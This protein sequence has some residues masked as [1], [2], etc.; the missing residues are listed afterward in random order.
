MVHDD[1]RLLAPF[2]ILNVHITDTRLLALQGVADA[3][4]RP[5]CAQPGDRAALLATPRAYGERAR[6]ACAFPVR[7]RPPNLHVECG[8]P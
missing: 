5:T 6:A 7:A 8:G 3:T 1:V 4:G 2:V